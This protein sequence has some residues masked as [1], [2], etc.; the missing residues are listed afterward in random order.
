[1]DTANLAAS[2]VSATVTTIGLA[3]VLTQLSTIRNQLDP[4]RDARGEDHLAFWGSRTPRAWY[5]YKFVKEAPEGPILEADV[6]YCLGEK[7][8]R[9][10]RSPIGKVG[11]ASWTTLLAV[12]HPSLSH[13]SDQSDHGPHLKTIRRST[14]AAES[15]GTHSEASTGGEQSSFEVPWHHRLSKRPLVF[16][17]EVA[18]TTIPRTTLIVFVLLSS[19]D[20]SYRYDGPAGLRLGYGGYNGTF[21]ID[22]PIGQRATLSFKAHERYQRGTD[23]FPTYFQRRPSKCIDMVVGI[24]NRGT[25]GSNKL[26]K[27]AFAGR[28]PPGRWLL[29]LLPK[30]FGAQRAAPD[31]F[32]LLGGLAYEV[33]FLFRERLT[34]DAIIPS[35]AR[36]LQVPSLEVDRTAIVYVRD[37]EN[38]V[39]ADCLDHLP[40]SPLAWSIH[41]GLKDLIVAYAQPFLSAYRE[42][43]ARTLA[44]A[45]SEHSFA[46]QHRGWDAAFVHEWMAEQAA[47]AILYVVR[48]ITP[49]SKHA[50]RWLTAGPRRRGD[51]R[52]SGDTCR[53]ITGLAELIWQSVE[54]GMDKTIFWA[55][56][57]E[58]PPAQPAG[59]KLSPDTVVAIIK[60]YL[61]RW[62]RDFDY[63][64]YHKLPVTLFVT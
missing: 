22:W 41:R 7:K 9:V 2:W 60:V 16:Y 21:Q 57:R 54:S 52:A 47:S 35:H 48:T 31:L 59:T 17:K 64:V 63:D 4:F 15:R 20:E 18:C 55:T 45:V 3:S 51:D 28:K 38:T 19:A 10:S 44:E 42:P 56:N 37:Q 25:D 49:I 62:S 5:R 40:W 36:A 61:V 50:E 46:L 34:D 1:M 24:V 23:V 13:L 29:K 58:I 43:L 32:N 8:L 11:V 39:I 30:R 14:T 53:V 12:F 33:D 27:V 26:S 6:E